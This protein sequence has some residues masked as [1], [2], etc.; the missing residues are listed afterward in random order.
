MSAKLNVMSYRFMR[1]VV[2]FDLPIETSAQQREYRRFRKFLVQNGFVMLQT[3][4]YSKIVLNATAANALRQNIRNNKTNEGLIEMLLVT[5]R[6]F[7][8]MEIVVGER[9]SDVIDDDKRLVIL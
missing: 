2:F 3:S 5:E 6:Q 7:E 8:K 1:L 4:V 9:R